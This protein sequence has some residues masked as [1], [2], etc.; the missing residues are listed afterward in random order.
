MKKTTLA[1]LIAIVSVGAI[2]G[3]YFFTKDEPSTS[4]T[5]T[6]SNQAP[7]SSNKPED[8]TSSGSFTKAEVAEHNTEDDCWTIVNDN[9]YDLTAYIPRHPGGDDI[10]AACGTDG[11]SLFVERETEDGESV[12]SGTPHSDSAATQLESLKIGTLNN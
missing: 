4:D 6:I 11:T 12:G 2:A 10:L 8:N 1:I 5:P 3:I 9:V 7:S